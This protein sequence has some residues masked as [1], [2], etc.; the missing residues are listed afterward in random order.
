[1]YGFEYLKNFLR[2]EGF[3]IN[4]KENSF[5]FKYNGVVYS[6][7]KEEKKFLEINLICNTKDTNRSKLLEVCNSL[8]RE[9]FVL[10]LSVD[11]DNDVWCSYEFVPTEDTTPDDYD[12]IFEMMDKVTDEL[13]SRLKQ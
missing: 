12:T 3:R 5:S 2:E 1:M 11:S 8:N 13:F 7:S 6:V 9:K 10:K 4:E